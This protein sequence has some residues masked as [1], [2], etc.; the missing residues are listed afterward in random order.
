MD[1]PA[2]QAAVEATAVPESPMAEAIFRTL[3]YADVFDFPMTGAEIYHFLIGLTATPDDVRAALEGS[4]YLAQRI[5]QM[6]GYYALRENAQAV[7]KR[8]QHEAASSK[9]WPTARRFGHLIAHLPF[10]RMVAV[11]GALAMRNA[12]ERDDIDYLIVTTPGRV[13]TS[14]GIT[15]ALVRI[16]KLFGVSLCPNY[17]MAETAL[18]QERQSLFM[19]H[20]LAQMVPLSGKALYAAMRDANGWSAKMLPNA[21]GPFYDEVDVSPRGAGRV[22]QRLGE[23]LLGGRIGDSLERWEQRRK[24]RKFAP[25]A[26]QPGSAAVLDDERIKG[27]FNDYGEPTIWAYQ[28]RLARFG[29]PISADDSM[30][31]VEMS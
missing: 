21:I 30:K 8:I 22:L 5:E 17:V 12:E 18:F 29:L 14:R 1:L 15:V 4:P 7:E 28:E 2:S 25:Q 31:I 9:L 13:W 19:A 26:S 10:V 11:T 23:W 6:N 16:A 3:L 27:H 24:L 20:E